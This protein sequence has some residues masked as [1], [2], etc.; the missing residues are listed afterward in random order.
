[1]KLTLLCVLQGVV[2]VVL[3]GIGEIAGLGDCLA[4]SGHVLPN[5]GYVLKRL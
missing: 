2:E 3:L 5:A 1:M 4:K